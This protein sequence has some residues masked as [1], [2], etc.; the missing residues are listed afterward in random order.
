MF[1]EDESVKGERTR[2]DKARSC[3]KRGLADLSQD[4][5]ENKV[6]GKRNG[7]K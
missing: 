1:M 2:G 7:P 6:G 5:F 4:N 3:L